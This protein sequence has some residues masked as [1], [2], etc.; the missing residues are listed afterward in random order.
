MISSEGDNSGRDT[1]SKKFFLER[2]NPGRV[3]KWPE[4]GRTNCPRI[5][6]RE[7]KKIDD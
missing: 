2:E 7:E 6:K 1:H 5:E 3:Q 4:A